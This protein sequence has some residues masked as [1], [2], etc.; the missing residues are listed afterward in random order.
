MSVAL[1]APRTA[2]PAA[3]GLGRL[4]DALLLANVF[5]ITFAKIRWAAGGPDVNVSDIAAAAFVAAFAADRVGRRDGRVQRTVAIL[6]GFFLLFLLVYLAGFYSLETTADRTQ[7][8]KGLVKFVIH[9]A[10]LVCAVAQLANRSPGFYWRTLGWFTAGVVA[11]A[12]YGVLQLAVAELTGGNLDRTVLSA[13]GSYQRGGINVYGAVD[14]ASVFRTNALTLDPNHLG[15]MLIVPLLVLLP[16]Y[17]RLERGNRWRTPLAAVLAFLAVVELS[18][19]SR[20]GLLGLA[21]GLA[22]LALPYRPYLLSAR[23]LV[24]LG[25]AAGVVAAV[26]SQRTGF[27]EQVV[28]ARTSFGGGSTNVHLQIYE[29]VP[30]VIG[31]H[32]LFGLGLNTFSTY[33]EFITGESDWGPHSYY[34]ALL[35]ETG[36]V[37]T[38]VFLVYLAYLFVRLGVLRRIGRELAR[39]GDAAA[40]RVLP[41]GWGLTAALVGTL[42][43]NVFYLTMQMYYF[44]VLALFILAAPLVF[45]GRPVASTTG[46]Q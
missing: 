9:F 23:L 7:F 27:F 6:L 5:T 40:A 17:L 45:S 35:A 20:S 32:P 38:V 1:P 8:V 44:F 34:I 37:G 19:L 16:I 10:F 26:V 14:G 41:L 29:L 28:R 3:A 2:A 24:P 18:T 36:I 39:V 12:A 30:P 11:N 42:A 4:V 43:A 21:A 22:V 46:A 13:I 31:E 33:Y 25:L 15:I